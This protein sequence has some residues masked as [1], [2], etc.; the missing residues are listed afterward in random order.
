MEYVW[1]ALAH[2]IQKNRFLYTSAPCEIAVPKVEWSERHH[3]GQTHRQ[4]RS[5]MAGVDHSLEHPMENKPA[6][7]L[8]PARKHFI[9]RTAYRKGYR[10]SEDGKTVTSPF[11]DEPCNPSINP[12]GYPWFTVVTESGISRRCTVH[13]LQAYQKFGEEIYTPKLMVRPSSAPTL[14]EA[15]EKAVRH[16]ERVTV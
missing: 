2:S 4:K 3:L 12:E 9:E 13:R 7:C 5:E 15:F 6:P 16:A 11:R 10:V 14:R 8:K 1:H